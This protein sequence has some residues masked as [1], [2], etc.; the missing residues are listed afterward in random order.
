[1]VEGSWEVGSGRL[2]VAFSALTDSS[3]EVGALESAASGTE[4]SFPGAETVS[5]V[6]IW[7]IGSSGA[8][9]ETVSCVAI[10]W[11]TDR[12]VTT[13]TEADCGAAPVA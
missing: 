4:G 8:G 13:W 5:C 3:S 1:M 7:W 11:I 12:G 6:A 10:W 9:A 2:S